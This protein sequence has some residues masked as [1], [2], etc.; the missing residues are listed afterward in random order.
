M[1]KLLVLFLS[2]AFLVACS[3]DDDNDEISL[4]FIVGL[5]YEIFKAMSENGIEI[6]F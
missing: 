5:D 1:K 4:L 2:M 3:S 6:G